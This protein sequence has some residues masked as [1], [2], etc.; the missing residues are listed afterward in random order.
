[1]NNS[2]IFNAVNTQNSFPSSSISSSSSSSSCGRRR[3]N[4]KP[5]VSRVCSRS[6]P[7]FCSPS[8]RSMRF[9]RVNRKDLIEN[10]E[11]CC[12]TR[13]GLLL[14]RVWKGASRRRRPPLTPLQKAAREDIRLH[15]LRKMVMMVMVLSRVVVVRCNNE[16]TQ[17]NNL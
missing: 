3:A 1:M 2:S 14:L 15:R 6:S 5:C 4:A 16:K 17:N 10:T 9:S 8:T 13:R 7:R 11:S 12:C